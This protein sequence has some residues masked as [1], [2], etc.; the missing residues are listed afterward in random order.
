MT[1]FIPFLFYPVIKD[2]GARILRRLQKEVLAADRTQLPDT[3]N[4]SADHVTAVAAAAGAPAMTAIGLS[5]HDGQ[6]S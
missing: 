3:A 6:A 2:A 5:E 1:T 4:T